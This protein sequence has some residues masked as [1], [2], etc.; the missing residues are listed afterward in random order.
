ML[1]PEGVDRFGRK[2]FTGNALIT[3]PSDVFERERISQ[4]VEKLASNLG[5]FGFHGGSEGF[6]AQTILLP[7]LGV[8]SVPISSG[9]LTDIVV[10]HPDLRGHIVERERYVY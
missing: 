1:Q 3:L 4:T 6:L 8:A 9:L 7:E 10:D 5:L 2:R